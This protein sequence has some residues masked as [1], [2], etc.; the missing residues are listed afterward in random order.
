MPKS[1]IPGV[2]VYAHP[3]HRKEVA[4]EVRKGNVPARHAWAAGPDITTLTPAEMAAVTYALLQA[5]GER[6]A[7]EWWGTFLAGIRRGL[8]VTTAA[9]VALE[10]W[11]IG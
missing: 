7:A 9:R 3:K 4:A 10:R 1:P 2:T 8:E 11:D 6:L 5:Q